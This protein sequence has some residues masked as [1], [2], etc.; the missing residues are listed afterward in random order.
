MDTADSPLICTAWFI[1]IRRSGRSLACPFW[2]SGCL[3]GGLTRGAGP[4][5]AGWGDVEGQSPQPGRRQAH[6][7]SGLAAEMLLCSVLLHAPVLGGGLCSWTPIKIFEGSQMKLLE[8]GWAL[9][10]DAGIAGWLLQPGGARRCP[11]LGADS[12]CSSSCMRNPPLCGFLW[13][14]KEETKGEKK[15][16]QI[17]HKINTNLLLVVI[18]W[19]KTFTMHAGIC[20]VYTDILK[21]NS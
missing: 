12:G 15:K 14:S 8:G 7:R 9:M 16:E 4:A 2:G 19:L 13:F 20:S 3:V 1:F 21:G 6:Q 17:E 10:M 18:K 5:P 11:W